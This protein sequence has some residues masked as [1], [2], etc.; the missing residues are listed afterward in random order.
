ML[1][2]N[3]HANRIFK[4]SFKNTKNW[5]IDEILK[6][7][8]KK[9]V[10]KAFFNISLTFIT[11]VWF[12]VFVLTNKKENFVV[13]FFVVVLF[14]QYF[15][16]LKKTLISEKLDVWN[17]QGLNERLKLFWTSPKTIASMVFL[18]SFHF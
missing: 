13:N 1:A 15:N 2:F 14:A 11:C 10:P 6:N 5:K 8:R 17:V 3:F 12:K 18:K 4:S 9:R 16:I 7:E